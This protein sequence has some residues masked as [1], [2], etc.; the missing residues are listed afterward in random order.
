[1]MS[2]PIV[3]DEAE[4][5]L[6][7]V[8]SLGRS[9]Y[10]RHTDDSGVV[11][12]SR[13]RPLTNMQ[14]NYVNW[15][16]GGPRHFSGDFFI[17]GWLDSIGVEFDVATDED[18]DRF[19]ASLLKKYAVVITGSH[20]EYPTPAAF[21]AFEDYV[22][23]GGKLMYLGANGFF[24]ITTYLNNLRTAIEVRRG[25][26]AQRNWT[27]H[28]AEL[29]HSSTGEMGGLEASRSRPEPAARRWRGRRGLGAGF[30]VHPDSAKLLAGV[31]LGL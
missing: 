20:P 15:L 12:A 8:P 29:Y 21:D 3:L 4:K 19:G 7:Q 1:M 27:S 18:I 23:A 10:D 28:A 9:L 16:A 11:Y 30:R 22:G 14:P 2:I 26:A 13:L 25:Y 31:G 5:I 24:W 17:M 6:Q